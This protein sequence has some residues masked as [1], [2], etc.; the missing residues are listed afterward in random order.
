VTDLSHAPAVI[1][2]PFADGGERQPE[3]D[4]DLMR[5]LLDVGD[6]TDARALARQRAP[7]AV[8]SVYDLTRKQQHLLVAPR[9]LLREVDGPVTLQVAPI[10]QSTD[11]Q[12]VVGWTAW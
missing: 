9:A 7:F 3:V 12:L 2:V 11:L 10:E 4:Y 1:V 6:F 5:F 8:V